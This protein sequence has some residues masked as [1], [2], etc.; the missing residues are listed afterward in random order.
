MHSSVY[1]LILHSVCFSDKICLADNKSQQGGC[2]MIDNL[3]QPQICCVIVL[4]IITL[5]LSYYDSTS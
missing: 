4:G 3:V 5:V 2:L 1:L